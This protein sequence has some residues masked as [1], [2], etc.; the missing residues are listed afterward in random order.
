[1]QAFDVDRVFAGAKTERSAVI[2]HGIAGSAADLRKRRAGLGHLNAVDDQAAAVAVEQV[3]G[4]AAVG[5]DVDQTVPG[6]GIAG[7]S[8]AV[9]VEVGRLAIEDR[10]L[11]R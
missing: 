7:K 9:G 2:A 3:E 5:G 4:V 8:L 11:F 6:G 10:L 1:M